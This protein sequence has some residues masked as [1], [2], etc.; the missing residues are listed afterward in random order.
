M[1]CRAG[2]ERCVGSAELSGGGRIPSAWPAKTRGVG[3]DAV[4]GSIGSRIDERG[5]ASIPG[6]GGPYQADDYPAQILVVGMHD[7][8]LVAQVVPRCVIMDAA[9]SLRTPA[10]TCFSATVACL[11]HVGPSGHNRHIENEM[12]A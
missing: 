11:G 6:A 7:M 4:Y 3:N 5:P 9:G 12:L 2:T 1:P 10:P 8:R